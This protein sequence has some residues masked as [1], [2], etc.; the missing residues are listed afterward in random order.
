M[1]INMWMCY[2]FPEYVLVWTLK[3]EYGIRGWE[4]RQASICIWGQR[5]LDSENQSMPGVWLA[6]RWIYVVWLFMEIKTE[7]MNKT[8]MSLLINM[9]WLCSGWLM[10]GDRVSSCVACVEIGGWSSGNG[11]ENENFFFFRIE[12]LWLEMA[13]QVSVNFI[14]CRRQ[15][16]GSNRR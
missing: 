12:S 2:F 6:E 11:N 4:R 13:P 8:V 14:S 1:S 16:N 5:Y 15:G 3:L 7:V 10:G 9:H